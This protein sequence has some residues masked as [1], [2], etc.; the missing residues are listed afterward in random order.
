MENRP[1]GK[2]ASENGVSPL[3][4]LPFLALDSS[5]PQQLLLGSPTARSDNAYSALGSRL[6]P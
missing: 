3:C 2:T 6:T 5:Y 4:S 1:P